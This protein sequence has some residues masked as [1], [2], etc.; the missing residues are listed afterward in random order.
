MDIEDR[1]IKR[2]RPRK[3]VRMAPALVYLEM[4]HVKTADEVA[5]FMVKGGAEVK[6]FALKKEYW[7]RWVAH[8]AIKPPEDKRPPKKYWSLFKREFLLFLC[9]NDRKYSQLRRK[10]RS[11]GRKSETLV[12]SLI[13]AAIGSSMGVA[14]GVVAGFSAVCLYLLAKLG[15]EAF[16]A[17]LKSA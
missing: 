5:Q 7:R 15:K 14:A 13:A 10:L 1:W 3:L 12:V 2:V 9:T 16:C 17:Y 4:G 8:A 6:T 11:Y